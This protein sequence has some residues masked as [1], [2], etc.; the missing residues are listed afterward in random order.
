MTDLVR[1]APLGQLLRFVTRNRIL[2]YPEE[3]PDFELPEAYRS[4]LNS[5]QKEEDQTVQS[6][7]STS[8]RSSDASLPPRIDLEKV[9]TAADTHSVRQGVTGTRSQLE[10]QS[11]P[12]D[13]FEIEQG[14]ALTRTKTAPIA[15]TKT[16]DGYILVDW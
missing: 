12:N 7:Q 1:E 10:A 11:D 9:D 5:S 15:P 8:R 4:L 13:R 14:L 6:S 2:Q 16:S 3:R